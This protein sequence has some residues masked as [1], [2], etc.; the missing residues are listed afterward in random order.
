MQSQNIFFNV[1]SVSSRKIEEGVASL[2]D[3]EEEESAFATDIG[4]YPMLKTWSGKQYLKQYGEPVVSSSKPAEE[5][6]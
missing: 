4:A 3:S 5:T 1:V 6:T 2:T